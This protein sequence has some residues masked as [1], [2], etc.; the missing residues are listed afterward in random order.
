MNP[1]LEYLKKSNTDIASIFDVVFSPLP[2]HDL[3]GG[4]DTSGETLS[5][6][7]PSDTDASAPGVIFTSD[8]FRV[9]LAS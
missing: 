6:A 3:V 7:S 5:L 9:A 2:E 1:R 8:A 4:I